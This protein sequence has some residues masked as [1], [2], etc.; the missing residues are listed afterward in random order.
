LLQLRGGRPSRLQVAD[1]DRDLDLRRKTADPGQCVFGLLQRAGDPG[2][3]GAALSFGE[4]K[5]RKPRLRVGSEL[6]CLSIRLLCCSEVAETSS[7]LSDLVVAGCGDETLEVV[8][9]LTRGDCHLLRFEQLASEP[10]DLRAVDST[11]TG[12]AGDVELIA[13][14]IRRLGPLGSAPVVA[15]VVAGADRDAVDEPRRVRP[16]RTSDRTRTCL[17][18]QG[19][20]SL[21]LAGLDQCPALCRQGEQ[22]GVALAVPL[23]ELNGS[24]E[25]CNRVRKVPFDEH[26]GRPTAESQ[27]RLFTGFG[28]RPEEPL[29]GGEPALRDGEEAAADVVLRQD[30]R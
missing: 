22:L 4:A 5:E 16:E 21:D 19:E 7:D 17:V 15:E 27:N 1:G 6:A 12:K 18:E 8:E 9:F 24:V 25:L 2:D 29:P 23:A 20:S 26:L 3:G 13:P 10:H 14:A 28:F 11:G 30:Q